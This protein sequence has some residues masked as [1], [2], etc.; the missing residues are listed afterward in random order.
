MGNIW[1]TP[2]HEEP[3]LP[4]EPI[5]RCV[6]VERR[7]ERVGKREWKYVVWKTLAKRWVLF[8]P[9]TILLP[10]LDPHL[11]NNVRF[12]KQFIMFIFQFM[13]GWFSMND[14]DLN[15]HTFPRSVMDTILQQAVQGIQ[16]APDMYRFV[17]VRDYHD[18]A[19]YYIWSFEQYEP[20]IQQLLKAWNH[21]CFEQDKYTFPP[22]S[23]N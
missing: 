9:R 10:Y 1:N 3:E 16:I 15:L 21:S 13:D 8:V 4:E 20:C 19:M 2:T 7:L 6:Y 12:K 11:Q 22:P 5:F 14:P 17:D 23:C 18:P